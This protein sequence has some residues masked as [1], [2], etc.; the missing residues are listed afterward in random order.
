[1]ALPNGYRTNINIIK[2]KIGPERRQE[3]LDDI[4]YKGTYLPKGVY[5][6][7]MDQ[8]LFDF[9][10]SENGLSVTVDGVKLP[11]LFLTIQRWSEFTKT[12]KFTDE[13]KNIEMPFVTIIRRPD[14]QQGQNQAG[15]WNI[16]GE[17]AYTYIKVPTWDGVRRGIDLYKVP[18]P[19]SVD[20][21]YDV[22]IFTNRMKDINKFNGR[23]QRMFQSRQCYIN[24]KGH[25]MPLHLESI[26]D[27]SNIDDFE[28][29]RFYVQSFEIKLLGY[30]LNEE[31]YEV[32][33]TINRTLVTTE[34]DE[35]RLYND[36]IFEPLKQGN[37]LAYTFVWKPKSENQFSF[38]AQYSAAFTQLQTIENISR[39]IITVNNSVV[40]DGTVLG[41]PLLLYANDVVN[42]KVTK[43]ASS[44][45]KFILLGSTF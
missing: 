13:Y 34:I 4:A 12:W 31:E 44:L 41:A 22:K 20:I 19:T 36:V 5:E 15:L 37:D 16:P 7:D 9:V 23:I 28:N 8:A 38:T 1:M 17:R 33:P 27:E 30:L 25:P 40:F 2:Q 32:V 39:I 29:R 26:S 14:I 35:R 24:V 10:D 6:E 21:T 18:Q 45:G 3:I 42:V 43:N 11:A